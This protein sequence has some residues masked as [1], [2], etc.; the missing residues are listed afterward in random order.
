MRNA[1]KIRAVGRRRFLE[2]P[3]IADGSDGWR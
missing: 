1:T 2:G 3:T